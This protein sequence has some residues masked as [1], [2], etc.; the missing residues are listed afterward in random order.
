MVRLR[1]LRTS[2]RRNWGGE[3]EGREGGGEGGERGRGGR[4]D[5]EERGE[6]QGEI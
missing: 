5:G 2:I 3:R 6:K 1:T 4:W